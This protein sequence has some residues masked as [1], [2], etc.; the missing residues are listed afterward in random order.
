ML[1][2]SITP[3]LPGLGSGGFSQLCPHPA[4]PPV[5][6]RVGSTGCG[7]LGSTDMGIL[8][9]GTAPAPGPGSTVLTH[10]GKARKLS[11]ENFFISLSVLLLQEPPLPT[12]LL[13][14][15][16]VPSR[17]FQLDPGQISAVSQLFL[18]LTCTPDLS[19][20]PLFHLPTNSHL[21]LKLLKLFLCSSPAN[22]LI[23][24]EQ[25]QNLGI[26]P[27]CSCISLFQSS[28]LRVFSTLINLK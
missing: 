22:T 24:M 10:P 18:P 20:P 9:L 14:R 26:F 7:G 28:S 4:L 11:L 21:Y 8:C 13:R 15:I 27:P 25:P 12:F 16:P 17:V 19:Y 1:P 23:P 5:L 2:V 3:L 6:P